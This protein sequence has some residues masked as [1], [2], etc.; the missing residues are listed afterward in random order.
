MC[1]H[2][3][4]NALNAAK[5]KVTDVMLVDYF[6]ITKYILNYKWIFVELGI[7]PARRVIEA[8]AIIHSYHYCYYLLIIDRHGQNTT[9]TVGIKDKEKSLS[10]YQP[11]DPL[12]IA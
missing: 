10:Q 9:V 8:K 7:T 2:V 3:K 11:F 12:V 4:Y 1:V 5:Q 6:E